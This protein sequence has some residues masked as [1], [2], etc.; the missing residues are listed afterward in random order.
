[1]TIFRF[2]QDFRWV[3]QQLPIKSKEPHRK[4]GEGYPFGIR[5]LAPL[6]KYITETMVM[7]R[8][9]VTTGTRKISN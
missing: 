6:A 3:Q 9:T 5:L 1:M 7:S 4:A 8:V 2:P